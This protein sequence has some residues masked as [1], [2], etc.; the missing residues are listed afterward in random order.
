MYYIVFVCRLL[1]RVSVI[2]HDS[3]LVIHAQVI[4]EAGDIRL[5]VCYRVSYSLTAAGAESF[6]SFTIFGLRDET[7]AFKA[8]DFHIT[9]ILS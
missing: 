6:A 3:E 2:A 1:N 5:A 9:A 7:S 4:V 8:P